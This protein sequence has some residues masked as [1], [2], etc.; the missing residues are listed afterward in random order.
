MCEKKGEQLT[1]ESLSTSHF[2]DKVRS[3][4]NITFKGYETDH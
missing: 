4:L 3:V 1:S 2:S